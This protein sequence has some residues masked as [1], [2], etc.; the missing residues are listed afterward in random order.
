MS[1]EQS[2]AP[3]PSVLGESWVVAS[4]SSI[5][6]PGSPPLEKD[7]AS[8]TPLP[9]QLRQKERAKAT[10]NNTRAPTTTEAAQLSESLTSSTSSWSFSGPEL[11]MPSIYEVPISEKS[12]VAPHLRPAAQSAH[13]R[14]RRKTTPPE[15][16]VQQQIE[17]TAVMSLEAGAPALGN[18]GS[19][20]QSIAAKLAGLCHGQQ[21]LL[22]I[23]INSVLVILI[24]HLLVLPE[25]IYQAQELFCTSPIVKTIYPHSCVRLEP[26]S[27]PRNPF[28][29]TSISPL[30]PEETIFSAQQNL[31]FIFNSTLITLIPLSDILKDSETLLAKLQSQLQITLPDAHNALDLEFQGSDAALRAAVWE[32]DSLRADLRSAIDSLLASPASV[33]TASP[34]STSIARDTRLAAQL[35]RR[36]EYLDRLRAQ[37]R[38]KAESLGA[39]FATLDDHLEAVDGITK[40]EEWRAALLYGG[41]RTVAPEGSGQ[42]AWQAMLSSLSGYAPFGERFFGTG[43]VGSSDEPEQSQVVDRDDDPWPVNTMALLRLAATYHRPVADE[44]AQL[45]HGLRDMPPA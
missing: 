2:F 35:R 6:E 23:T 7:P 38:S 29:S 25:I 16:K 27:L 44:V 32:F 40:R 31:Q 13:M 19:W 3:S 15:D 9:K 1:K 34:S 8:P 30:S 17:N 4:T 42:A 20:Y 10:T 26:R 39:R 18:H 5:K 33:I 36:A 12:W 11:V 14:K 22:R 43:K 45:A 28:K 37:I 24:L 41:E 21:A